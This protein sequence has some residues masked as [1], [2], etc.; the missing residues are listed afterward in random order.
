MALL[1]PTSI[2]KLIRYYEV[3]R[4]NSLIK[5]VIS[6]LLTRVRFHDSMLR[7][8]W[9]GSQNALFLNFIIANLMY[10]N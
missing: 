3:L 9:T 5:T 10:M 2:L 4:T 8:V 1:N 7:L 6:P